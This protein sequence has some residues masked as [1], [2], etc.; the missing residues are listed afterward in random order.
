MLYDST[1]TAQ[2]AGKRLEG[3]LALKVTAKCGFTK[4]WFTA[5]G[6]GTQPQP[7]IAGDLVA[8]AGGAPGGFVVER[9]ATGVVVW[10]YP[11]PAATV[12]PLIEAGGELIGGD[13]SGH[14]YAFRPTR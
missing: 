3:T 12:S 14:L 11:T 2:S 4:R 10:R 6:D 1:A 7:L 9:A 13:W 5:T 8:D